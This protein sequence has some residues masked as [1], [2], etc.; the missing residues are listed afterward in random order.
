MS[1]KFGFPN[2]VKKTTNL[3][4]GQNKPKRKKLPV[5]VRVIDII[6]DENHPLIKNGTY[7]LNSLGLAICVGTTPYNL[8]VN[9]SALPLNSNNKTYPTI[10]E[11]LTLIQGTK[12]NSNGIQF[13]YDKP[14]S[15]FGTSTP[16]GN[17][18]PSITQTITPPSQNLTYDQIEQGAVN[19]VDNS[20]TDIIV[21]SQ[22]NPSQA[23]YSQ[24]SD[25]HPLMPFEGDVIHE[26]RWG[27]SLRFGSTAKSL[28][29]YK[30][31]WST[32]GNN[33]DPITILRNGQPKNTLPEG[34]IP[35]TENAND[36]LSSIYLTSYQKIPINLSTNSDFISYTNKP[37]SPSQY[38]SPQ[39]L[40]SSD[41]I[42]LNAK[43]DSILLSG[44]KSIGLFSNES[45]NLES[46]QIYI[47]GTDIKLGSKTADEPLLLGNKTVDTLSQILTQLI[48]I[49]DLLS[50]SQI[51]PGGVASP[52][53]P[54]NAMAS[55]ASA[56][57]QQIQNKLNSLKSNISKTK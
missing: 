12:P 49:C 6:M 1:H 41:R 7:G 10:G 11:P 29:Q 22:D 50:V 57:F 9:Y 44:Q 55:N 27:N 54:M 40:L 5:V 20:P 37:I 33:G 18:F 2:L 34:W 30:N 53:A 42:I 26:G 25:I 14:L 24:K 16:N 43:N 4:S 45:I 46:K 3:F 23:T 15:F 21:S 52:D 47:D 38:I 17:Q 56:A 28:S 35:I 39:V 31:L 8:G 48:G 51:Y 19:I 36:D 32:S 13:F